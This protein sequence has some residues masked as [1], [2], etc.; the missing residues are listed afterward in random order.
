MASIE[1]S[2]EQKNYFKKNWE[3]AQTLINIIFNAE[4]YAR[5]HHSEYAVNT[6]YEAKQELD[7][8]LDPFTG[9]MSFQISSPGSPPRI[10]YRKAAHNWRTPPN[11]TRKRKRTSPER[12]RKSPAQTR[13]S[14]Y[15]TV[16]K[17]VSPPKLPRNEG[18]KFSQEF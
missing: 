4:I 14:N 7:T 12:T 18:I 15:F 5:Q 1:L 2:L 3:R 13:I 16:P 10:K 6:A 17:H 11:S 9:I 8:I